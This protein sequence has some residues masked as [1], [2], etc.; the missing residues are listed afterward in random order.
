MHRDLMGPVTRLG[1][2]RQAGRC[3]S[4]TAS[5]SV[6]Q[7]TTSSC[8][9]RRSTGSFSAP[10]MRHGPL[11]TARDATLQRGRPQEESVPGPGRN[12]PCRCGSGRKTKHCC[13]E[14]RGP[15]ED[16]LAR[17]HL[18]ALTREAG[19]GMGRA[20]RRRP[21]DRHSATPG[22]TRRRDRSTTRPAPHQPPPSRLRPPG[23]RHWLH[24]P[25]RSQP[26]RSRC[27]LRR[28]QPHPGRPTHRGLTPIIYPGEVVRLAR[29]LRP[30]V[31]QP[32][33]QSRPGSARRSL[34]LPA[35]PRLG[36][37]G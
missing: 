28:R 37:F 32:Q 23:P 36:A 17:A 26:A 1:P 13:G 25:H 21:P 24:P 9:T 34:R 19:L 8:S 3:S 16:Q 30:F 6:S 31:I 15:S 11:P 33:L 27:R 20:H 22:P 14:Q 10:D 18:A 35:M 12:Q 29:R 2:S 7:R 5:K 4:S